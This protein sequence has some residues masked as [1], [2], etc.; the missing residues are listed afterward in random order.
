MRQM[1]A[2]LMQMYAKS[3]QDLLAETMGLLGIE[4]K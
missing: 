2:H 3:S 1:S 4:E